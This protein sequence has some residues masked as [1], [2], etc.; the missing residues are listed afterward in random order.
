MAKN[1]IQ[2]ALVLQGGGSLGAYKAG[3]FNTLYYWIKNENDASTENDNI[4]M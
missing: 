1:N 2:R 4:L 3:V